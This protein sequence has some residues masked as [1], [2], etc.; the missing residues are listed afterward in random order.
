MNQVRKKKWGGLHKYCV[1]IKCNNKLC[2]GVK[3]CQLIQKIKA[4]YES[5]RKDTR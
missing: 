1:L 2:P 3:D 4:K 5:N